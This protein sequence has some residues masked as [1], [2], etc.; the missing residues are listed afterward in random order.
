MKRRPS[1][2]CRRR[3][4]VSAAVLCLCFAWR[5]DD[6]AGVAVSVEQQIMHKHVLAECHSA[7]GGPGGGQARQRGGGGRALPPGA[8]SGRG[9]GPQ[10]RAGCRCWRCW[11][12]G[13]GSGR[14]VLLNCGAGEEADAV[15][16]AACARM[17]K[18]REQL[19]PL[20]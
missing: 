1:R 4:V 18:A 8:G 2:K 19:A 12:R 11:R 16:D 17:G 15:I 5:L 10:R 13:T 9:K 20:L 7:L 14:R 3:W 6:D